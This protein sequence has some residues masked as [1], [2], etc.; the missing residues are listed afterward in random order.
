MTTM[1]M[2]QEHN[3]KNMKQIGTP[4]EEEKIYIENAAYKRIHEEDY[5]SKRIFVFMG[6]TEC[7]EGKYR[8]FIEAAIPVKNV[9]FLQNIP[10]WDTRTWSDVFHEIKRAYEDMIIVGWALDIKGFPPKMTKELEMIHREQFGGIHQVLFLMDSVE[11]D[12]FFYYHRGQH[13]QQREGFYIYYDEKAPQ[14]KMPDVKVDFQKDTQAENVPEPGQDVSI[15][16]DRNPKGRYRDTVEKESKEGGIKASSYALVAAI[17]LLI[18]VVGVGVYQKRFSFDDLQT[19]IS[20]MGGKVKTKNDK[21]VSTETQEA[22]ETLQLIP[23]Q[24]LPLGEV[25]ESQ[26]EAE[27]EQDTEKT[28]EPETSKEEEK[29]QQTN[30]LV[31]ETYIVQPGDTLTAICRERYGSISRLSAIAEINELENLDDIRVGQKLYL[32]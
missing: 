1:A 24:E 3:L 27:T 32:P 15:K 31:Y 7:C 18:S 22:E 10:V 2:E 29:T 12:E 13:L 14:E 19:A 11:G 26:V 9:E 6:H 23:V 5:S 8:T 17:V 21:N 4:T 20:T 30:A 16:E 28:E 25:R